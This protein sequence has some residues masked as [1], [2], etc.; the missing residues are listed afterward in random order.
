MTLNPH[1]LLIVLGLTGNP[2]PIPVS[3]IEN[4]AAPAPAD[5]CYAPEVR[6]GVATPEQLDSIMEWLA[7]R[8]ELPKSAEH[9]TIV[10]ETP[11]DIARMRRRGFATHGDTPRGDKS[12]Q[13]TADG[14]ILALYDDARRTIHLSSE[15][16]GTTDAGI[17]V[18]VHEMVHH[19]QNMAGLRYNCA[20]E[21]EKLAYRAQNSWL[22]RSGKSLESE[23]GIDAFT[24]VMR[25]NCV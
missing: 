8:F 15:W 3:C 12:E 24:M 2:A 22:L 20:G 23:F 19:L 7:D 1:V 11:A 9:P 5:R 10:I 4:D 14:D 18:L 13:R 16:N 25:G 6:D 17:S 21:R